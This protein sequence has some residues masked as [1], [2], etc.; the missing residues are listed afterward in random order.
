MGERTGLMNLQELAV[1]VRTEEEVVT[2]QLGDVEATEEGLVNKQ[3]G[4]VVPLDDFALKQLAKVL[5]M[6]ATYLIKCPPELQRTN[7]NHWFEAHASAE[8]QFT[9][10]G[11]NLVDAKAAHKV[12]VPNREFVLALDRALEEYAPRVTH[13]TL[14]SKVLHVEVLPEEDRSWGDTVLQFGVC[15]TNTETDGPVVTPLLQH[16]ESGAVFLFPPFRG[17]V[18]TR[19]KGLAEV[20]AETESH[21]RQAAVDTPQDIYAVM[22]L[23][24]NERLPEGAGVK[25]GAL[26]REN[27]LP[28]AVIE[29]VETFLT[30]PRTVYEVALF[31]AQVALE[32][33]LKYRTRV[34]LQEVAGTLLV[35]T[36][37]LLARCGECLRPFLRN[38]AGERRE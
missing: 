37:P 18:T 32:D 34:R 26:L 13:Y 10:Q 30:F 27:R 11:G 23:F 28:R 36:E 24:R 9:L 21:A 31:M 2:L 7:L 17:V 1:V 22:E 6:S 20:L 29:R 4:A 35:D 5:S 12:I 8:V 3:T 33:S 16:T 19:G 25:M 38:S 15:A 14:D